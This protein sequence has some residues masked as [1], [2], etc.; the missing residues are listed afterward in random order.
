MRLPRRMH[1]HL[2]TA[3]AQ[4]AKLIRR[5]FFV[6]TAADESR[7]QAQDICL[8]EISNKSSDK[9]RHFLTD[10]MNT[11]RDRSVCHVDVT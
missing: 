9:L 4:G 7:A 2:A 8:Q 3:A 1:N 11:T 10:S 5:A 6:G